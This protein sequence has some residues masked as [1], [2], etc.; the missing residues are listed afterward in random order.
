MTYQTERENFLLAMQR[1]GM[2]PDVARKILR[3]ANTVQRCAAAECNGDW[4]YDNGERTVKPCARCQSGCVPAALRSGLCPSCRAEDAITK[5][6]GQSCGNCGRPSSCT[7]PTGCGACHWV[8]PI[9]QTRLTRNAPVFVP[10][11]QGDPR[12]CC[13]KIAV[14]SGKSD[15]WGEPAAICVPTRRY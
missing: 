11:F 15:A 2:A 5:L 12:G 9:E 14:P 4:P 7:W 10:H 6:C 3:Y 13:V 8:D 1:E